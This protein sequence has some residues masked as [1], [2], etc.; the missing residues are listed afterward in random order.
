LVYRV[1]PVHTDVGKYVG[2]GPHSP[3]VFYTPA[4]HVEV[5]G[6]YAEVKV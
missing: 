1:Q 6:D 2:S 3:P 4:E 5:F